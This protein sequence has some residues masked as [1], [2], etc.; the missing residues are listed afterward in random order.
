MEYKVFG[1][2]LALRLDK[3]EEIVSSLKKVCEQEKIRLG[4][5]SAIGAVNHVVVGL[6][7]VAQ[8]QYHSNTFDRPFELTALTGSVTTKE[9]EVYLHLHATLADETGAAFGGH[10]N[11]AVVSATCELFVQ[12][13]SGSIERRVDPDV[14]LNVFVF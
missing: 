12:I 7:N 9:G 2:T 11:E 13:V 6:Y 8:Q 1:N 5:V 10:L 4:V 14:G 3:G